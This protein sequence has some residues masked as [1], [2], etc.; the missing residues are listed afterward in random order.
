MPQDDLGEPLGILYT[1]AAMALRAHGIIEQGFLRGVVHVDVVLVGEQEL[2]A[3]QHVVWS[4]RLDEIEIAYILATPIDRIGIDV[5]AA[6]SDEQT[7]ALED[8]GSPQP[9]LKL[10]TSCQARS[11]SRERPGSCRRLCCRGHAIHI[12]PESTVVAAVPND[13]LSQPYPRSKPRALS[14]VVSTKLLA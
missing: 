10:K 14:F 2:H 4:R 11:F 9:G 5:A 1:H 7:V 8:R 3:A 13:A 6:R 12:T